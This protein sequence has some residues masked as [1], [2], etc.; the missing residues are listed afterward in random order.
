MGAK[1]VATVYVR[2][3]DAFETV[4]LDAGTEPEPRLAALVT[5]PAAWEDGKL[6]PAAKR[7]AAAASSEDGS[8][9]SGG[10]TKQATA[11][12]GARR[13]ARGRK[14]ADSEGAGGQ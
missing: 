8:G 12:A 3:P 10:D 5:N 2:D 6:P 11:T 13:P 7:T 1:L 9:D 4:R 14:T